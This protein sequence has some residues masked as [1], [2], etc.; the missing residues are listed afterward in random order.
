MYTF[1]SAEIYVLDGATG[2]EHFKIDGPVAGSVTPALGDINDD[3]IPEI[4]TVDRDTWNHV[5]Y[6]H[7]GELL[8]TG[9]SGG[10]VMMHAALALADMDADGD[11]EIISARTVLDHEGRIRWFNPIRY[12]SNN[13]IRN[14]M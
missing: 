6:S 14:L 9:A 7:E 13:R 10:N 1:P 12:R 4:I 3:G 11:V 2:E 5:A 8:W